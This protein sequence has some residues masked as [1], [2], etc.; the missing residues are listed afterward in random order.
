PEGTDSI[1]LPKITTPTLVA[2]QTANNQ[3][4]VS[5]DI[6]TTSVNTGIKTLAGQE[7]VALQLLEMAPAGLTDR[8]ITE[9]LQAA[10]HLNLDFNVIQGTGPNTSTAGGLLGLYPT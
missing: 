9:D 10:Y 8:A 4:V 3:A 1:N 5:Q 7:D 2:A 6:V